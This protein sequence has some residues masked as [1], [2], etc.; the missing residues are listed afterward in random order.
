MK[1]FTVFFIF[2]INGVFSTT[3]YSQSGW[4]QLNTG[5][6]ASLHTICIVDSQVGYVGGSTAFLKTTNGGSNWLIMQDSLPRSNPMTFV[7]RDTGF[8]LIGNNIF[9]TNNGG[10][11]WVQS[12][13]LPNPLDEI[14]HANRDTLYVRGHGNSGPPYFFPSIYLYKSIGGQSWNL[15][16]S[17]IGF[18]GAISFPNGSEGW[19]SDDNSFFFTN[20]GGNNWTNGASLPAGYEST[21]LQIV[22]S[23]GIAISYKNQ[24]PL[25]YDLFKLYAFQWYLISDTSA[26]CAA[27]Y[28]VSDFKGYA[29]SLIKSYHNIFVTFNGGLNWYQQQVNLG[30][31]DYLYKFFF[32]NENT[33]YAIGSNG[34][35]IKTTDGGGQPIGIE[36]INEQ[37]PKTF[38]LLQNYPNPFNPSTNIKFDIPNIR[39]GRDR[40]VQLTIYDVLGR[41]VAV[42]VNEKLNHGAYS[43][44]WDASNFASGV[45]FYKLEAR[46]YVQTRK[47]VLMK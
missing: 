16:G 5:T 35:I 43:V 27:A 34:V 12:S 42:L 14:V 2:L 11:N 7:N 40:S 29:V 8:V 21:F 13:S 22:G 32:I 44:D 9:R 31:S 18:G 30:P 17:F 26:S 38:S 20:N 33:G 47:M 10:L 23:I 4:V 39:N 19:V 28:F 24:N 1:I 6:N 37:T 45:Y 15:Y 46:D 25:R 3:V 36:Q 41:V